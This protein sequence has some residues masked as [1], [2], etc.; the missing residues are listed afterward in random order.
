MF[1]AFFII[2]L[3]LDNNGVKIL[4]SW[5][6]LEVHAVGVGMISALLYAPVSFL[7]SNVGSYFVA[8]SL[9]DWVLLVS[10]LLHL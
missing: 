7:F 3:H 8:F 1:Q 2:L 4:E 10:P 9:L 6:A 5:Q